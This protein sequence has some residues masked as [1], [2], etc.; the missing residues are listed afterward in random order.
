[1]PNNYL[2]FIY[3]VFG[4]KENMRKLRVYL[5]SGAV[6][7]VW[8]VMVYLLIRTPK[9]D[10]QVHVSAPSVVYTEK[11]S[12][13]NM[14]A[15]TRPM[16]STSPVRHTAAVSVSSAPVM[17]MGGSRGGS[18]AMTVHTTSSASPVTIGS[19]GAGGG[20]VANAGGS[21]P[22]ASA[23]SSSFPVFACAPL[24]QST[25][26]MLESSRQRL[27]RHDLTAENTLASVQ[28]VIEGNGAGVAPRRGTMDNW[29]DYGQDD[30]PFLDP[31]G[32][33]TWGWIAF[34]ALAY[35]IW[36]GARTRKRALES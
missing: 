9:D 15:V 8:C 2:N 12:Q 1:M 21:R 31:V 7:V 29:D 33:V 34:L 32:D 20:G 25:S 28:G 26:S 30:E 17:Q 19:G 6:L 11:A 24:K 3:G 4:E 16:R 27:E 10:P 18:A 14:P 23:A 13:S 5:I 35:L 36:R 22:A